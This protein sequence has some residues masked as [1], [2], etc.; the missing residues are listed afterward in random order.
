MNNRW[1]MPEGYN[2]TPNREVKAM[3]TVHPT[4][5]VDKTAVQA[6]NKTVQVLETVVNDLRVENE[7]LKRENSTLTS[8][9]RNLEATVR[10][11]ESKLDA[12]SFTNGYAG[13]EYA[14][15]FTN[16]YAG[17]EYVGHNF[18]EGVATNA[19]GVVKS[20]PTDLYATTK[21]VQSI[22]QR[23]TQATSIAASYV[24]PVN[25]LTVFVEFLEELDILQE[26]C[27]VT[28]N[29][30]ISFDLL[31]NQYNPSDWI[32]EV[33]TDDEGDVLE[34]WGEANDLWVSICDSDDLNSKEAYVE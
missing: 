34:E 17:L 3:P 13:L 23:V 26:Y 30:E 29:E 25:P 8:N 32:L 4:V 21:P 22:G 7:K 14:A 33:C 31:C 16:G 5:I 20:S 12:A 15:S 10:D 2:I 28:T 11:L 1:G 27:Q 18:G 19:S 9:T 24:A 6:A